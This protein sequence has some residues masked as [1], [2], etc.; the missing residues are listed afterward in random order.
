MIGKWGFL[1]AVAAAGAVAG[2][3][4]SAFALTLDF[5][6]CHI[7][8]GCGALPFGQVT[9]TQDPTNSANT[10]VTVSGPNF[11]FFATTGTI[12][13][14]ANS[15]LFAFN[16]PTGATIASPVATSTITPVPALT[17]NTGSFSVNGLPDFG[18]FGF[19]IECPTCNGSSNQ[20]SSISFVVDNATIAQL[21][22]PNSAGVIFIADVLINGATGPIDVH[23]VPVPVVGAGL[24]GLV[25][26]CG[27]LL[28]LARRRRQ[29]FA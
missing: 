6:S 13:G 14:D 7:A 16:A 27:G 11:T 15:V 8:T 12:K 4:T 26:A 22:T 5:N 23:A 19:A 17:G 18:T 2:G 25:M 20:I 24:P 28:A 21:T 9:L 10:D 3:A 29:K 1:L